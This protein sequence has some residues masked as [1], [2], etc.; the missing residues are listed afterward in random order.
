[1]KKRIAVATFASLLASCTSIP[2]PKPAHVE[3]VLSPKVQALQLNQSVREILGAR[4]NNDVIIR[5]GADGTVTLFGAPGEGFKVEEDKGYKPPE[6]G[7]VNK[8][9][10]T[11]TKNSPVCNTIQVG[12]WVIWYISPPCPIH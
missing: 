11:T 8:V 10:V 7:V 3:G 12:G 2:S 9:T 5:V 1:M 6:R 4:D